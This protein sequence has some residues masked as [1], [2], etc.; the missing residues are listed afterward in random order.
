MNHCRSELYGKLIDGS[1]LAMLKRQQRF[2][3]DNLMSLVSRVRQGT[4][5][6]KC[7]EW[8]ETMERIRALDRDL[9]KRFPNPVYLTE[10][11]ANVARYTDEA[12]AQ[13]PGDT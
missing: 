5:D 3:Q 8:Q 10:T 9:P 2:K 13:L 12:L 11:R 4:S 6:P 1:L 7:K